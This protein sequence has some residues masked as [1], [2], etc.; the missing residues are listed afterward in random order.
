MAHDPKTENWLAS[1]RRGDLER[2]RKEEEDVADLWWNSLSLEQRE[3]FSELLES[4]DGLTYLSNKIMKARIDA[5]PLRGP[6]GARSFP[7]SPPLPT[8]V[9]SSAVAALADPT[10]TSHPRPR[11]CSARRPSRPQRRN[12]MGRACASATRAAN[13]WGSS[14]ATGLRCSAPGTLG[15]AQKQPGGLPPHWAARMQH[16]PP[17]CVLQQQSTSAT[18]HVASAAGKGNRHR[19]LSTWPVQLGPAFANKKV[20]RTNAK[21]TTTILAMGRPSFASPCWKRASAHCPARCTRCTGERSRPLLDLL[22]DV[23]PSRHP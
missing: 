11:T 2:L 12:T 14:S 9:A 20:E 19:A 4:H 7:S 8:A 1:R 17:V 6:P 13:P 22:K 5:R 18:F 16:S 23:P 15:E 3:I 21:A 10:T